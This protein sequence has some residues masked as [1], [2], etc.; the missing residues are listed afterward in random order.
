MKII[1][2]DTQILIWGIQAFSSPTQT[3]MITKA[4]DLLALLKTKKIPTIIPS[5]VVFELLMNVDSPTY[6]NSI[7]VINR[8]FRVVSFNVLAATKAATL[9]NNRS[10]DTSQPPINPAEGRRH[11]IKADF[12]IVATAI[13]HKCDCICSND[14]HIE[15]IVSS[16]KETIQVKTLALP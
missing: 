2:L 6:S 7:Q 13:S 11:K 10:I 15:K 8:D 1:C 14:P 9:Y 16:S 5:T 12:Q 4:K 3:D